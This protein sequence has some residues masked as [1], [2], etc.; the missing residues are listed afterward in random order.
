MGSYRYQIFIVEKNGA[1]WVVM[2]FRGLNAGATG[3]VNWPIYIVKRYN[4]GKGWRCGLVITV[5]VPTGAHTFLATLGVSVLRIGRLRGRH[6][7]RGL[8][9]R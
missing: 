3:Q 5:A 8:A 6:G 2:N 4:A 7:I 9:C 1:S